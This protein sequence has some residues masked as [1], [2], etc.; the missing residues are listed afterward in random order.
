MVEKN[1]EILMGSACFYKIQ[2]K[3]F[4]TNILKPKWF[5]IKK[6]IKSLKIKIINQENPENHFNLGI[7]A[8]V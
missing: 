1:K 2:V 8:F 3:V 4:K 6:K 5:C 7:K